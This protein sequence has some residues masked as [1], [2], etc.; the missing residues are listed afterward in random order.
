MR[1]IIAREEYC[2]LGVFNF[3]SRRKKAALSPLNGLG[4]FCKKEEE[5][6]GRYVLSACSF[7]LLFYAPSSFDDVSR[8]R[9]NVPA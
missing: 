9:K 1:N 3:L 8:R 4:L 5:Q 7:V 6:N 2:K